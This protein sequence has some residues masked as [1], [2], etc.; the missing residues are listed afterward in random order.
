[1]EHRRG[2]SAAAALVFLAGLA[3]ARGTAGDEGL[4]LGEEG[5]GG[6]LP[7]GGNLHRRKRLYHFCVL[8]CLSYSRIGFVLQIAEFFQGAVESALG[9]GAG[10]FDG[11]L[12]AVEFFVC[13]VLWG[14]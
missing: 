10:A 7:G 9:G 3:G 12:E 13:R 14:S 1:M 8:V 6:A 2:V 4:R 5:F 11:D